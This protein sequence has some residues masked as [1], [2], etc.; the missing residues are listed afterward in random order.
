M[1]YDFGEKYVR[2][3]LKP[4]EGEEI[5][6]V[7][8]WYSTESLLF[9]KWRGDK[10]IK[11]LDNY[12]DFTQY[13]LH[14][15]GISTDQDSYQRLLANAHHKRVAVLSNETQYIPDARLTDEVYLFFF[16]SEPLF[17]RTFDDVEDFS[18]FGAAMPFTKSRLPLTRRKPSPNF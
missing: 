8:W 11:G 1:Y 7:L 6:R 18:N 16:K 13:D 12:R 2:C 10:R 4:A 5:G 9:A 14:Y 3:S 15:V 17:V